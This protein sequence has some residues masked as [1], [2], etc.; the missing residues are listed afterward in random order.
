MSENAADGV[1]LEV[2][3]SSVAA[4]AEAV[5]AIVDDDLHEL[6]T[7]H[8]DA[9]L[10]R[11]ENGPRAGW[12]SVGELAALLGV[13]QRTVYRAL[14]SGRL[15]GVRVGAAWRVRPE[16]LEAWLEAQTQRKSPTDARR[17]VR[18]TGLFRARAAQLEAKRRPVR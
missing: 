5:L 6:A 14:T 3:A 12:F 18:E 15:V 10:T 2:S 8:V 4:I 7:A 16:D 13:H 1:A 9:E 17:G 11:R